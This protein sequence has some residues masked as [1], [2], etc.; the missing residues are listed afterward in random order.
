[1]THSILYCIIIGIAFTTICIFLKINNHPA[2]KFDR[3]LLTQDLKKL[4][5]ALSEISKDDIDF[6]IKSR[7][8]TT[9]YIAIENGNLEI[10]DLL[11]QSGANVNFGFDIENSYNALLQAAIVKRFDII[12]LLLKNQ[13]MT[14]IHF[15][16]FNGNVSKLEELL[17]ENP[18]NVNTINTQLTPLHFAVIGGSVECVK[19]L[20][21]K[22]ADI[23]RYVSNYGTPLILAINKQ[24][25]D[26]V[27]F[28]INCGAKLQQESE[29]S[30][31]PLKN[32]ISRGDIQ[33]CE[34]LIRRGASVNASPSDFSSPLHLAASLG[35]IEI[36][37]L[38]I[39]NGAIIDAFRSGDR[40]TP[41]CRAVSNGHLVMVELLIH[42]GANID[43]SVGDF[44][45]LKGRTPLGL[46]RNHNFSRNTM[47]KIENL[48]LQYGATDYGFED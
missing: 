35:R 31:T 27:S 9:L 12:E 37:S 21:Q 48:L 42:Y 6:P 30:D 16:A 23:N 34:S 32:A 7:Q 17:I 1:M 15:H 3:A 5:L 38:L 33:I 14:G 24:N 25:I 4:R 40:E 41:L 10:V 29:P 26:F 19:L 44:L 28:I 45:F 2:I 22:N 13:A 8:L 11:I 47:L 18:Q 36:A 39:E 20:L 43:I 46:S